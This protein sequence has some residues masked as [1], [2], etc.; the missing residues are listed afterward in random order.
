MRQRSNETVKY[1][2]SYG[3]QLAVYNKGPTS[4]AGGSAHAPRPDKKAIWVIQDQT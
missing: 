4:T 3:E 2:S 1:K